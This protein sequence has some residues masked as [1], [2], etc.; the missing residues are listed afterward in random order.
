MPSR[1]HSKLIE[2]IRDVDKV[3][4]DTKKRESW[5]KAE[6]HLGLLR[7]NEREDELIV[8]G[9]CKHTFIHSVVVSLE[10]LCPVNQ[11]DLLQWSG[12]PC[13]P[14][15]SYVSGS[16]QDGIWIERSNGWGTETLKG[17]RQLVFLRHFEGLKASD[18]SYCEIHQEYSHLLDVHWRPEHRAYCQFDENGDFEHIVSI[19]S[20]EDSGD[21]TLVSFK[22][23]PLEQY[24]AVS[25]SV[26]VRMYHFGLWVPDRLHQDSSVSQEPKLLRECESFFYRQVI[27]PDMESSTR[28]VQ[29]VRPK[30]PKCEIVSSMR[31]SWF[32]DDEGP[33]VQF[34]AWDFRNKR[35]TAISTDPEATANY[36][37]KN[38]ASLPF[39][40]SPA[41]FSP[42]VLHKYKA[43]EEKY[44]VKGDMISCRSAWE[45]RT[46]DVNEEGQVHTYICYLRDLPYQEQLYWQ[47]FN[48]KPKAGISKRAFETD[49][50]A[51]FPSVVDSLEEVLHIVRAW[52]ESGVTWWKLRD[53]T[54]L[55][56]VSTPRTTSR[57]EWAEA[58]SS[59]S[60][61]VIEGFQVKAIRARLIEMGIAF[62]EEEKSLK[63]IE[64]ILIG[65][66]EFGAGE[67]LCGLREV[68]LIRSK[69]SAHSG[70]SD[71]VNLANQALE[72]HDT[73][74]AH[75]ESVCNT[76][77][78]EL[79]LIQEALS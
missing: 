68:H 18:A 29:F 42:E 41:F 47:S 75:F 59:L 17:A 66:C 48:E 44:S 50:L 77:A 22:R 61:L 35:I 55:E 76:V 51:E 21:V 24:L 5:I 56:R 27:H 60:K 1:A 43:D 32:E 67:R 19:T 71:A 2:R 31:D 49:F 28:G 13:S 72:A 78:K 34:L 74:S 4:D 52:N 69:V 15:A 26:L 79:K 38:G 58:I 23:E 9:A 63:L 7:E 37:Q 57:K 65:R 3:P 30:R 62:E 20:R 25:D 39:E 36:F 70:G 12:N 11:D 16:P 6:R 40:T 10:C 73:Y 8:Y 14:S 64:R 53:K 54:L 33:Y 46:Y 45:L